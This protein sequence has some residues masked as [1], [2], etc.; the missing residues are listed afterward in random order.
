MEIKEQLDFVEI[1][2]EKLYFY[3]QRKKVKNMNLKVHRDKKVTVS[4]PM[5][6]PLET[7]KSFVR[8]KAS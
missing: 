5:R 1:N 7:A 2:G 8:S 3:I 4:I 6:L